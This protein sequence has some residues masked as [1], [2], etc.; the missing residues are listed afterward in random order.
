EFI[1]KLMENIKRAW[2]GLNDR[3]TEGKWIWVDGTEQTSSMG[4]WYE[5]EPND[6]KNNEDC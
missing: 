4:Y 2:I 5:G 6:E 1:I 3:D